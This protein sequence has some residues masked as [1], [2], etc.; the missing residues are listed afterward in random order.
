MI[1]AWMLYA[2]VVGALLGGSGLALERFLRTHGLPSRWVWVGTILLSVG[3]PLGHWA[4]EIRPQEL[5]TAAVPSLP[6]VEPLDFPPAFLP[7]EPIRVEVP[8]ESVL[9]LLDG[10]IMAAWALATGLL[11]L[12]FTFILFRTHHLRHQWRRGK[13]GGK[14][15]LFSDDWGPAVV[16]FIRPQIVLPAWCEDIDDWALR[17][18]LDHELEHVRAGDL[19]LMIL[20]GIFPI[21]FP[22]HLPIWWQLAR[23]RTAV[24]ADCD[25]RVLGRN[26]GQTR[27]YV[28]LLLEVGERASRHRPMAAMLSEPYETLKRRIRI[29]T[30]PLPNRPWLRGGFLVGVGVVLV[31]VA[32]WAPGPTDAQDADA[33]PPVVASSMED[34]G[35]TQE[36]A[37][38]AVFTPWSVRPSIR[39][40]DEVVAA[41]EREYPAQLKE[42]GIGGTVQV[43]FFIDEEARVQRVMVVESSGH[44]S[45]D[46]AAVKVG[47]IIQFTPAL[48]RDQGRPVWISLPIEFTTEDSPMAEIPEPR[49]AV[50][51][52]PERVVTT[53][54]DISAPVGGKTGEVTGIARDAATGQPLA[55]VQVFVS[56]TGRGTLSNQEGRFLIE[57]VPV[58]DQEVVAHFIGFAQVSEAVSVRTEDR[59]EVDFELEPTAIGLE[60][61][62]VKGT[63]RAAQTHNP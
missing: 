49:L 44:R 10:P 24:E 36:G 34:A 14:T 19:R 29:M 22:W 60:R 35:G 47:E 15:V 32:C 27:P 7:L 2:I 43:W 58:G 17:F 30:M 63:A 13:A 39:N 56:G 54:S 12:F 20:T 18:V 40:P 1:T 8:P 45:L 38:L 31:A 23:L 9:R 11:L 4:W 16:G 48:N 46:D 21:F 61:L 55:F 28:D 5:P 53:S 33:E 42:A 26:P 52:T 41:L 3:W 51:G 37:L 6:A 50:E 57:H 25:R 59:T 62:V